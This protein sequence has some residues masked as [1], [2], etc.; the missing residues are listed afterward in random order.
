[1]MIPS[2]ASV[3][4]MLEGD[5]GVASV[6]T[7]VEEVLDDGCNDGDDDGDGDD[8]DVATCVVTCVDEVL[9]ERRC[10]AIVVLVI[11]YLVCNTIR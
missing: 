5:E 2:V 8:G 1:M 9:V 7:L 10:C 11:L 6:R 4:S 3:R